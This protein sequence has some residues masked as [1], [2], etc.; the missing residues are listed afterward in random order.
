[1]NVRDLFDLSLAGKKIRYVGHGHDPHGQR[2]DA[3][4]DLLPAL[5]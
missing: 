3:L 1:V 5:P 2:L 4:D